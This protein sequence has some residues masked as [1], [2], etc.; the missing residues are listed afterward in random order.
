VVNSSHHQAVEKPGRQLRITGTAPDG[1]VESLEWTGDANWVIGVQW[2]PER[3][4]GDALAERLFS[5]L[6]AAAKGARKVPAAR[7]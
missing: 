6:M 4:K 7:S 3:M 1:T 2:H 5:E